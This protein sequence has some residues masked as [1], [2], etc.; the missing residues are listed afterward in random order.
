MPLPREANLILSLTYSPLYFQ[1]RGKVLGGCSSIAF[2]SW[3]CASKFE[4]DAWDAFASNKGWNWEGLLPYFCKS[5]AI[6]ADQVNTFPGISTTDTS[7]GNNPEYLGL[8]GPV[9]LSYN[10]VDPDTVPI[11]VKTLNE[12]G[13]KTNPTPENGELTGMINSHMNIDSLTGTRSYAA[14]T[15]FRRSELRSNF[16]VLTKAQATKILF[17]PTRKSAGIEATGVEFQVDSQ[18]FTAR[19]RKE[20]ILTAGVYQ[21]PQLLELSGIGNRGLLEKLGI[22][23]I[24]ELPEVGKNLQDHFVGSAQYELKPGI[25]TFDELRNNPVFTA[26]QAEIYAKT[27]GGM[28]ASFNTALSFLPFSH[29]L[30][31]EKAKSLV[32]AFDQVLSSRSETTALQAKQYA[33]QREWLAKGVVPQMELILFSNG[34]VNPEPG[35]SYITVLGAGLHHISR[36]SVHI[37]SKDPLLPPVIDPKVFDNEFDVKLLLE[38]LKLVQQVASM[39]PLADIIESTMI[40][41]PALQT[42]VELIGY[43]KSCVGSAQHPMGTASMGPQELGGVVD[44]DLKV[45]GTTNLRVCDASI[46]PL[47]LGAHLQATI[48]AIAEKLADMIK[49]TGTRRSSAMLAD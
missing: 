10:Q 43:L 7:A 1:H 25:L 46:I 49:A 12:M 30:D 42:D 18:T 26:E 47:G 17:N 8:D 15:Y 22:S 48:Y 44:G 27:H 37:K 35:K 39:K 20:V 6:K 3:N 19:V 38:G 2:L 34:F 31:D 13:I 16:H 29:F 9:Q 24:I 11:Y 40:P 36:G 33:V 4:Y 23:T 41:P 21:S 14:T 5:T 32:E 28:L 45:Y